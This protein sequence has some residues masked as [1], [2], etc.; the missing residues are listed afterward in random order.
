MCGGEAHVG[1]SVEKRAP[2]LKDQQPPLL[3]RNGSGHFVRVVR[4]EAF[5]VPWAGRGAAFGDIDNDGDID[6]VVSN[7]GQKAYVLRNDGGNRGNWIR[8]ETI[9]K[10]SN[11][12]GI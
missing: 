12:D 7:A 6:V 1:D 5:Q 2:N 8:I 4:G 9:G 10:K 3:L 11:R